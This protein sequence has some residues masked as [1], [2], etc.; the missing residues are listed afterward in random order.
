MI[1]AADQI[2]PAC[3]SLPCQLQH[4]IGIVPCYLT[5]VRGEPDA[6]LEALSIDQLVESGPVHDASQLRA[7]LPPADS[8]LRRFVLLELIKLDMALHAESGC[9]PR[10]E[11]YLECFSDMISEDSIP[12][13][14]VLEEIQLRKEAGQEPACEEYRRRFPQFESLIGHLLRGTEV[15][16]AVGKLRKPPE[17]AIGSEID[18][19][20]IIKKLGEG[21]FAHVFLAR[22]ISMQR[23]V[24][25]KV[26]TGTG[27][28]PQVL[29]Q[30]DHPNI[31]RV[32]DQRTLQEPAAHLLYMQ[33]HP[34]GTLAEVVIAVRGKDCGEIDGRILLETVDR[35][36]LRAAQVV[37]DRSSVRQ[38][39]ETAQWPMVVAWL[40]VQLSHAL[41]DAHVLGMLHR[42]VKPA[43]V[44]L[45]A[46][47]IP[48]LADFN[49]SFAG[50][51]GRAGA[52]T[53]FGGSVGYMAPE[54]LQAISAHA[55][56]VPKQVGKEADIYSLAILLWELWQGHRPF[57]ADP[58]PT[59]W[60]EV[61]AQQLASRGGPLL[62]PKRCGTPSE[63]V[64]EK[65]LRVAL[66]S[67]VKKRP[68]AAAEMAGRLKLALHPE[69]AGLLDPGDDTRS[70][71]IASR[72]PW[73]VAGLVIL[74][75]NIAA[76][77]LNYEYNMREIKM[78]TE[79]RDSL[80]HLAACVNAIVY[81]LGVVLMVI[82]TKGLV[83]AIKT[84]REGRR[85]SSQ[86]LDDTLA[87]G[88][89]AAMIGGSCWIGAGI[90]Y[91][92]ILTWM[93]AE[94]TSIQATHFFCSMLICG[95]VA[96][97]YPMFGMALLVT[98]VYYPMLIRGT[99]QDDRFDQ[100]HRRMIH[101]CEA[102]L[103][104]AAIIPLL[105]AALLISSESG[106]RIFM[107]LAIGAGVVGLLASFYAYRVIT[108]TWNRFAEVLST[109][110]AVVPGEA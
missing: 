103:L 82:Y 80:S 71:R 26:S 30:F 45:T 35:S 10:L 12:V 90:V 39:I 40:G 14:L 4:T 93:Y 73:L 85:V 24:A 64:L 79:M 25:L 86:E 23:L 62:E 52:A 7:I 6:L 100:R 46:E 61:V 107:L 11:R 8:K 47:G 91:T 95:G 21:A 69:A 3:S 68:A 54:H 92:V 43:N 41:Q 72:S 31:V 89:R 70:S 9:V 56:E 34:G 106:S 108:D 58:A 17:L 49:V 48:K 38:W 105:G 32:F 67:E 20:R 15:T 94:F 84:T 27:D 13:D 101:R 96:M 81:P 65:S 104:V 88:H 57:P 83:N 74:L 99:M 87:L 66:Q 110:T 98:F 29:A 109:K 53:S 22:Q 5:K 75:P 2:S 18:D 77:L 36:L 59:S 16:S 44:L 97:V 60:S 63:R 33:Y 76:G 42:D 55:L 37:P 102:Y 51:A 28:E 50:A 78:T 19:F 1:E